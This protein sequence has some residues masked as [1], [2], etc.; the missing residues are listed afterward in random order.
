MSDLALIAAESGIDLILSGSDLE[1]AFG[2]ENS[3]ITQ[4]F[5]G[6]DWWGNE[7]LDPLQQFNCLTEKAL[8]SNA[9]N[10]VGRQ[11][12]EKAIVTDLAI[13]SNNV[14]G[15]VITV[16]TSIVT[17]NKLSIVITIDGKEFSYLWHPSN[18]YLQY[19]V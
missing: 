7:F 17:D 8:L 19:I 4:M 9:L 14:V 18:R 13:I 6:S 10:S 15:T 2:L 5:G 3:P 11:E 16:V 1:M 12:I